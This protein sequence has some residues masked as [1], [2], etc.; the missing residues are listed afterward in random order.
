LTCCASGAVAEQRVFSE[1]CAQHTCGFDCSE[2]PGCGWNT[3]HGVCVA[4]REK[5]QQREMLSGDCKHVDRSN[6]N[7]RR[8]CR[9]GLYFQI[10]SCLH[11]CTMFR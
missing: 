2:E 4:G 11:P 7:M 3:P 6:V 5:T 8:L 1:V 9:R 10:V